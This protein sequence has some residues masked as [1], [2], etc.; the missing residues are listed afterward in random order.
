[1]KYN[2]FEELPVWKGSLELARLIYKF[3]QRSEFKKDYGLCDQIRKAAVLI[4]SNIVEGYE[5]NNNVEFLR[6]LRIAKGSVGEVRN[7]LMIAESASY[8]TSSEQHELDE[9]LKDLARQ[10]AGLIRYLK[11]Y[12][13]LNNL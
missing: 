9:R 6:F 8:I 10:L 7:Q 2:G 3:S 13:K 5:K 4:S 12:K 11:N 1:M